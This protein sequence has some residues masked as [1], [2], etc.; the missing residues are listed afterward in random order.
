VLVYDLTGRK[1]LSEKMVAGENSIDISSLP[2]GVY[3]LHLTTD[4]NFL[5]KTFEVVRK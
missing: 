4:H 1:V 5:E 2:E 3:L